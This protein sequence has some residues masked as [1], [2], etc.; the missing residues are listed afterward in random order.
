MQNNHG[1]TLVEE[2]FV[3]SVIIILSIFTLQ[4]SFNSKPVISLE[5]QCNQIISLLEEGK[6]IALTNHEKVDIEIAVNQVSYHAVN[7]ERTVVLEETYQIDNSYE[8]HFN[9][10]GNIS[11]GSHFNICNQSKCK[12]IVLNVGSGTFYVK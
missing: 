9:H 7:R 11:S 1:F 4:F 2:L 12:S 10:N 5:Q 3:I 8:F 6:S